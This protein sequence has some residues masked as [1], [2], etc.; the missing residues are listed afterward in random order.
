MNEKSNYES[1]RPRGGFSLHSHVK[2]Q[3]KYNHIFLVFDLSQEELEEL[4][5]EKTG[6]NERVGEMYKRWELPHSI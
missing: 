6:E 5:L 4:T 1:Q 2:T 3:K